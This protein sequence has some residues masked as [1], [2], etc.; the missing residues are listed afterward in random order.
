MGG[1]FLAHVCRR[2]ERATFNSASRRE[3][4]GVPHFGGIKSFEGISE[5]VSAQ[6]TCGCACLHEWWVGGPR[7]SD[8][9]VSVEKQQ[10]RVNGPPVLAHNHRWI[11]QTNAHVT[12]SSCQTPSPPSLMHDK[13]THTHDTYPL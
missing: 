1:E 4:G 11:K 3:K 9:D 7:G 5:L 8:T 10:Q 13:C 2:L 12:G 6:C